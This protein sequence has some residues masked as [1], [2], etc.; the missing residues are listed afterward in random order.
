LPVSYIFR[1]NKPLD[2]ES[3]DPHNI[4]TAP[5][6]LDFIKLTYNKF[7]YVLTALL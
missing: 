1:R 5:E 7:K 3:R 4:V 2:E 6:S